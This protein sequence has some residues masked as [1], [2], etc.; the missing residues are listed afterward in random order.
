M[1]CLCLDFASEGDHLYCISANVLLKS[2]NDWSVIASDK[3][4]KTFKRILRDKYPNM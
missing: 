2:I 4:I 1:H 3:S